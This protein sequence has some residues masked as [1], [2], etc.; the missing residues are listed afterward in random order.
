MKKSKIT[1]KLPA[2]RYYASPY[3]SMP[4]ATALMVSNVGVITGHGSSQFR[5][6]TDY[7]CL[8]ILSH[9]KGHIRYGDHATTVNAGDLFCLWPHQVI[10]YEKDPD[11]PWEVFWI[12]LKG[13]KAE[14][15]AG[16]LGFSA[17]QLI[18]K[19]SHP[20]GA[21][22]MFRRLIDIFKSDQAP[23]PYHIVAMMYDLV[24]LVQTITPDAPLARSNSARLVDNALSLISVHAC[25]GMNVA[26]LAEALNVSQSTLFRA[27]KKEGHD[28]PLTCLNDARIRRAKELLSQSTHSIHVIAGL[29]GFSSEK[30]FFQSF[31]RATGMTPSQ[32]REDA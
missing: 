1:S 14:A 10:D 17:E 20:A 31:R 32:W 2:V 23:N 3:V 6:Q 25:K 9:G 19:P 15:F 27:F 5:I 29:T 16:D 22:D 18:V 4:E 11:D 13:D 12:H 7:F 30:Y 21:V 28:A 24:P 8:H 26:E